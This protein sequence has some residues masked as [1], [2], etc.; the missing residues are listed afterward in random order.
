MEIMLLIKTT[1]NEYRGR[2]A[3][4]MTD[5]EKWAEYEA[6]KQKLLHALNYGYITSDEYDAKIQALADRLRI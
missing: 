2:R 4:H 1:V 6:G 3:N 5:S